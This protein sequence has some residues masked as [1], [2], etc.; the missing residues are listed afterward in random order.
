MS[1]ATKTI[2]E[3][4]NKCAMQEQQIAELTAKVRWF[5][6]QFRLSRQK[7]FGRSSEQTNSEQLS[8]FN[9]AEA[10][11]KPQLAEPTV[12]E[13][14][15]TRRKKSGHR[16]EVLKDLPVET[17]EY[18]LLEEE[19]VDIKDPGNIDS[20]LPWSPALPDYCRVPDKNLT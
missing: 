11:A 1:S 13:I 10:E 7:R 12:G 18:R 8:L 3:L 16:E 17:I 4:E 20:L 2:E 19:N 14:T 9:E 15:Y 6:E 5:E